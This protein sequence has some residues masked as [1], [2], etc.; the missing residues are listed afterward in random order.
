MNARWLRNHQIGLISGVVFAGL[1]ITAVCLLQAANNEQDQVITELDVQR[2]EL[3]KLN[4]AK[5]F[6]SKKNIELLKRDHENIQHLFEAMRSAATHPS[7][8]GPVVTR[9]V[10]SAQLIRGT[11]QQLNLL[12]GH[13][14]HGTESFAFGFSRYMKEV[15]CSKLD[16]H[17]VDRTRILTL[18]GKQLVAV[19]KLVS[20]L[21]SNNVEGITA[22]HRTEVEPGETSADAL[23]L[24]IHTETNALYHTYPL[25]LRFTCDTTSL[26]NFLNGNDS[27]E[28]FVKKC[29][30]FAAIRELN[31]GNGVTALSLDA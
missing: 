27:F 3:D 30:K 4:A 14:L 12:A 6:P 10:D 21:V 13:Q 19:E 29:T 18:L 23:N 9:G 2:L 31:E 22:V 25:E 11:V 7:L 15:P 17:N 1:L 5:L 8:E 28:G 24:P 20:L 26:R 16:I